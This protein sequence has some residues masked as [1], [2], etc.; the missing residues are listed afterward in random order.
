MP[1]V[2]KWN[3]PI[4]LSLIQSF[5]RKEEQAK[6]VQTYRVLSIAAQTSPFFPPEAE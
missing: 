3:E 1:M 4:F 5:I 6:A 2:I